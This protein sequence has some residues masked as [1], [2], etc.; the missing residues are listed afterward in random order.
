MIYVIFD[1]GAG[2]G[3]RIPDFWCSCGLHSTGGAI[4]FGVSTEPEADA[5][6]TSAWASLGAVVFKAGTDL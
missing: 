6:T 5:C 3:I 4:V 2:Q 1:Y